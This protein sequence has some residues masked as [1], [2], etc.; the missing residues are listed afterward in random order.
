MPCAEG[1][2]AFFFP[3][4]IPIDSWLRASLP[5]DAHL[6]LNAGSVTLFGVRA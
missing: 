5:T 1:A 4:R 3:V 2:T 6:P